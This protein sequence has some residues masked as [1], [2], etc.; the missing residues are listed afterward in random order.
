MVGEAALVIIQ[1][2]LALVVALVVT[3]VMVVMVKLAAALMILLALVA[4]VAAEN[5]VVISLVMVAQLVFMELVGLVIFNHQAILPKIW[6]QQAQG[7]CQ[8]QQRAELCQQLVLLAM[9]LAVEIALQRQPCMLARA[10]SE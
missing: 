9:G 1:L 2:M 4:L 7:V 10:Q 5:A 6:H 8:Q 3:Q